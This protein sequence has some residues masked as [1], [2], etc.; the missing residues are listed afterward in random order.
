[1]RL[2]LSLAVGRS[3]PR[4]VWLSD[5]RSTDMA[6][7]WHWAFIWMWAALYTRLCLFPLF[8]G[9][10]IHKVLLIRVPGYRVASAHSCGGPLS[11][12]KYNHGMTNF[13]VIVEFD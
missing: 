12:I 9:S 6:V 11:S 7:Y 3:V 13:V 10:R 2:S 1:M 4:H 8:Y 5:Y